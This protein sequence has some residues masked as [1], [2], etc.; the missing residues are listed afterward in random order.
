MLV[1]KRIALIGYGYW[2]PNLLRNLFDTKNC[3]V[4]YCCDLS[5][6]QLKKA[7]KR[8]PSIV[9]TTDINKIIND[10]KIDGIVIATPTKTHFLIAEQALNK[11]KDVLI[12]KPMAMTVTE[13]RTLV[14]L[15]KKKKRIVMVDHTFLFNNAVLKI[16]E[17]IDKK[18][19]GKIL[20]IDSVRVN[21]G[22]FQSDVNVV[23]D[24]ATHDFSIIN[25]LL[26][27]KPKSVRATGK[28]H[29]NN[30]E[31]VAYITV[32]Y[33]KNVM[34]H[35]HISWLSPLKVRQ[36]LIIG[37]KKMVVY[38]EDEVAE[39]IRVYDKGVLM[40]QPDE[41]MKEQ[42]MISYRSGD[43]WLPKLAII[44][45]LSLLTNAFIQAITKRQIPKSNGDFALEVMEV[46]EASNKS[47]RIGRKVNL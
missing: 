2:G 10:P 18:R 15:A 40:T 1:M 4:I 35:I 38:N 13:A 45:P 28:T 36:M 16:K 26:G 7:K 44:E 24:L 47:I 41:L 3:Q 20:Y 6:E 14:D 27:S 19:L 29:F 31:A 8:Y 34:A 12:E 37:T 17:L 23:F 42:V 39:K 33:P 43:V 11:N 46:L 22:L 25:F 9:T 21:L 30:Q 32:N 5:K